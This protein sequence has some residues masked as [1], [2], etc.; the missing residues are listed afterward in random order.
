M[1]LAHGNAAL[2][3]DAGGTHTRWAVVNAQGELLGCG[4]ACGMT[5]LQMGEAR[6]REAVAEVL[7]Q[8]AQQVGALCPVQRVCAGVTGAGARHEP[9]TRALQGLLAQAFHIEPLAVCVLSDIEIAY[10]A[11]YAPGQGYLVCAGTGSMAAFIDEQGELHRA[12]GRGGVLD[13]GGS[14]Y[15]IAREALRQIWRAEDERPGA[16]RDSPMARRVF[17]QLGSSDWDASRRFVYTGTRG[18]MGQLALAVAAAAQEDPLALD[19][20][21]RAGAELARLAAALVARF[22]PRPVALAGRVSQLHPVIAQSLGAALP[23]GLVL[24]VLDSRAEMAAA[25]LAL[26]FENLEG[27]TAATRSVPASSVTD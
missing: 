5:A 12:G 23:A 1:T 6:G 16:W 10:R 15:W 14:G 24:Q 27:P 18:A 9:A 4:V 17:E 21:Q 2:G 22:G 7:A 13:D 25:R 26:H 8:L 19:I 11:V 20:L 3:L